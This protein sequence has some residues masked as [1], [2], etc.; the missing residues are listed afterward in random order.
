[1][2]KSAVNP[3]AVVLMALM[4]ATRFHH[5]GN[6][7]ALPDASLAIFF[8]AG[9]WLNWR[10]WFVALLA[11]AGLID[12]LAITQ[13]GVSDFCISPAYVFL[14]PTYAALW[15]AGQWFRQYNQAGWRSAAYLPLFLIC[16]ATLAFLISN[17]SFFLIAEQVP[18]KSW[19]NYINRF[20]AYYPSYLLITVAYGIGFWAVAQAIRVLS[21]A[22]SSQHAL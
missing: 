15:Q 13:L 1:M 17:G 14:I 6:A 22:K 9:L 5:T 18:D 3:V 19:A 7:F 2:F 12:Y 4:A 16:S 10:G 8:T 20:S 11:Q 21:A